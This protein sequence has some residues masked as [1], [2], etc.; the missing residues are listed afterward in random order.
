MLICELEVVF[1]LL[2]FYLIC[3]FPII[4]CGIDKSS[5]ISVKKTDLIELQKY[6]K[7]LNEKRMRI[8]Q[9]VQK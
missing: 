3:Y 4:G 1:S 8:R 9:Y 5:K 6:P 7:E 2:C